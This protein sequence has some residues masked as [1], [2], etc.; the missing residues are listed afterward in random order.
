M[1]VK[2]DF[3]LDQSGGPTNTGLPEILFSYLMLIV[4]DLIH[5]MLGAFKHAQQT[6]FADL[7]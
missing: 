6:H 3:N 1:A 5:G 7:V 2:R 4:H